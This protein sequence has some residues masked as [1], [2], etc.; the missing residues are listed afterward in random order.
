MR[1]KI[2]NI[3][4]PISKKHSNIYANSKNKEKTLISCTWKSKGLFLIYST[5]LSAYCNH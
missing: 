1:M 3:T 4:F 5:K 2:Y